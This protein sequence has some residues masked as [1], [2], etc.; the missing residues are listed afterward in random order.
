M[1]L[2]LHY[3]YPILPLVPKPW[4]LIGILPVLLGIGINVVADKLFSRARTTVNSFGEPTAMITEG[5]YSLSRNPMYLGMA[6][7][8][9]GVAILLGS[10]SPFF[11]I[12]IFVWLTSVRFI[13][14]EEQMLEDKFGMQWQDYAR[15]VRRWI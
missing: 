15:R 9:L 12:P 1:M 10:L 5:I 14:F 3:L 7:V 4:I 13:K 8:L 6:L 2:A 11:V